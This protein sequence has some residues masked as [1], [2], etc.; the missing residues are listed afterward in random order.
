ML[1][2]FATSSAADR[3][4][5]MTAQQ[6]ISAFLQ[7]LDRMFAIP[8]NIAPATTSYVDHYYYNWR[9]SPF[10]RGAYSH[11]AIGG[12]PHRELLANTELG[13]GR[14]IIAGEHTSLSA[15]ATVTG[16]MVEGVRAADRI[17]ASVGSLPAKL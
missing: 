17:I 11:P 12:R 13:G 7:Q 9:D 14:L 10:V 1:V 3:I 2:G 15:S 6:R 4:D 16:A 5:A 8:G